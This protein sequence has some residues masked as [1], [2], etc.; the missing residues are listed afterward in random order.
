M[1]SHCAS[2]DFGSRAYWAFT[3]L[4]CC[5][6]LN[7]LLPVSR[8]VHE[9]RREEYGSGGQGSVQQVLLGQSRKVRAALA[10]KW[11]LGSSPIARTI[12]LRRERSEERKK[13]C[14][15]QWQWDM[16]SHGFLLASSH[17]RCNGSGEN[18]L[19]APIAV[20][21]VRSCIKCSGA[22]PQFEEPSE[23]SH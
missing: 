15:H 16:P 11:S 21:C 12:H 17:C 22:I 18:V 8:K 1:L 5:P 2:A 20:R 10:P 14:T 7:V 3:H 23:P 9:K 19:S 13:E 6:K 4:L